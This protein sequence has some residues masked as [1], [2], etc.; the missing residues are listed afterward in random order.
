MTAKALP[1]L[2]EIGCEEIPARFLDGAREAFASA[3]D[4][5]LRD[6]RLLAAGTVTRQSGTGRPLPLYAFSTPR[7]LTVFVPHVLEKQPDKTEEA[8]GPPV[9]VAFDASGKPTRAADSFA[10]KNK[11]PVEK[12]IRVKT[13]KGE[14]VGVKKTAPGQPARELLP[15]ILQGVLASLTFPKSMYWLAKAAPRFV[16]PVRWVLALL[17]EGTQAR[18]VPF[19]F[20]GVK[21]GDSTLGHRDCGTKPVRVNGFKDYAKKLAQLQVELDPAK[22]RARVRS[23]SKALLEKSRLMTVEDKELEDWIVNSTEW[24]QALEG[25]FEERSLSL[26]REILVTVMRDHQKYFAVEDRAGKIQP[27]FVTIL[28]REGDP[29]GLVRQGHGRV[30][31]ARFGDAEFFWKADQKVRLADRQAALAGVTYQAELGSYA[32]KVSRMKVIASQLCDELERGSKFHPSQRLAVMRAVEL[33]KCDLTTQ[34]VKEFPE[35]QGIV[36]G[37]YAEAQGEKTPDVSQAIYDHYLPQGAEDRCP[38]SLVGAIVSLADKMDSVAGGFATG[39]DPTGSSDPF[40]LRRRANGIIKVLLE[41]SLSVSLS[42]V[43]ENTLVQLVVKWQKPRHAVFSAIM[44]FFEERLRYYLETVRKLHYDTVRAVMAARW[45]DPADVLRRAEALERVRNSDD[46]TS[47]SMAAKRIKN[48]LTKSAAAEELQSASVE[49]GKLEPG[50]EK[51]LFD[52]Y[53]AAA[54][55]AGA[56]RQAG[57]YDRSLAEIAKLRPRVDA[58]FDKVLVMDQDAAVRKNRLQ[59]LL[60]LDGLFSSIAKFAEF[61]PAARDVDASTSRAAKSDK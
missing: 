39:H 55:K 59:L 28:N 36:G 58:F 16:R 11:L 3:L 23:E 45:D 19:E 18:V 46:F 38:R 4:A 10:A 43:V 32:E 13:P 48:I 21:S 8:L 7:R 37:L 41:L 53:L 52:A 20:A 22:R 30:L 57:E 26:P 44:E 49:Q 17:G 34:M 35:L 24:P 6:A 1:L 25:R 5:A 51:E 31:A 61:A 50:P 54:E 33:C 47:L 15:G 27:R 56:S 14:Y 40:A 60:L 42:A 12:L 29:K 9:R 2:V